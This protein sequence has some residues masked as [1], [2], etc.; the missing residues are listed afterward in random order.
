MSHGMRNNRSRGA[1]R[2]NYAGILPI[3]K[4]F[5]WAKLARKN[6]YSWIPDIQKW[7][8]FLYHD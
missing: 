4:A 3:E 1:G 2:E 7:T 6:M 8:N 5:C